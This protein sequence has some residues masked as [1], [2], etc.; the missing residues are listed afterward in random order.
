MGFLLWILSTILTAIFVPVNLI[1]GFIKTIWK[2]RFFTAIKDVDAKFM[3]MA[4]V[5]DFYGNVVCSARL[6]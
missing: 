4:V 3:S 2:R 5:I 6:R 1:Y